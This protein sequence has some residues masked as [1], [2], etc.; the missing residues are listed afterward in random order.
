MYQWLAAAKARFF[1][2]W[3]QQEV[4][5]SDGEWCRGPGT[6]QAYAELKMLVIMPD[7]PV[8]AYAACAGRVMFGGEYH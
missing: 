8:N 2:V 7:T 3:R 1:K 4:K 5:K 6:S